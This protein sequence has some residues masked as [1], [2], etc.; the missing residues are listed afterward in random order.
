MN[1]LQ[2]S[3]ENTTIYCSDCNRSN[4]KCSHCTHVFEP[5]NNIICA[6]DWNHFC[7][8]DSCLDEFWCITE[9]KAIVKDR[10]TGDE[11]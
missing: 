8:N 10:T 1:P 6:N 2:E 11:E 5:G 7:D 3:L 9:A 4:P